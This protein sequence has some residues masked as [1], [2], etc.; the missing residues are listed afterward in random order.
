MKLDNNQF[1]FYLLSGLCA[2]TIL[3]FVIEAAQYLAFPGFPYEGPWQGL[4]V[5]AAARILEGLPLYPDPFVAGSYYVYTPALPWI[6]AGFL[7]VLGKSILAMKLSALMFCLANIAGI[8]VISR[9]LGASRMSSLIGV[10][11]YLSFFSVLQ[12]WHLSVRPDNLGTALI[13]WG[14]VCAL[15]AL[16]CSRGHHAL[17]AGFLL[18]WL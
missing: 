12:F 4:H 16:K 15:L 11:Y 14:S 2:V 8:F 7:L 13:L 17:L 6:H 9:Q 10:A 1:L 3:A 5:I 18:F